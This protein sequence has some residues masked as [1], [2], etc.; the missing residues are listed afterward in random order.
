MGVS[1]AFR[2]CAENIV[3]PKVGLRSLKIRWSYQDLRTVYRKL[4]E[5]FSKMPFTAIGHLDISEVTHFYTS[6]K[7]FQ[8]IY[9]KT[10]L[11]KT[12]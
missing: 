1:H 5:L 11:E 10:F 2:Y 12:F 8:G 9:V 4:V 6:G 3:Y 7:E